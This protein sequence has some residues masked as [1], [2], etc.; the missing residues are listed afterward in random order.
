MKI[1]LIKSLELSTSLINK[2]N[3][4]FLI[5]IELENDLLTS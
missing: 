5:L 3:N 2:I 1:I 4:F